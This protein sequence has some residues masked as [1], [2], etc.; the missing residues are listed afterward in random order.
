LTT[1]I[2][3]FEALFPGN[4]RWKKAMIQ[5]SYTPR[6]IFFQDIPGGFY[7]QFPVYFRTL[8]ILALK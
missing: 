7:P 8:F 2:T 6:E 1:F 4:Y 5:G 3:V